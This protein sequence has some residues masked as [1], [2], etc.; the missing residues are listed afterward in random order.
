MVVCGG[1]EE[2]G[3]ISE[4]VSTRINDHVVHHHRTTSITIC[5]KT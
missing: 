5:A 2:H 4:E 3:A 1:D